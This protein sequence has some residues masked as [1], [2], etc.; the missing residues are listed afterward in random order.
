V[1]KKRAE[2]SRLRGDES[3]ISQCEERTNKCTDGQTN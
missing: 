1:T 2:V 3:V